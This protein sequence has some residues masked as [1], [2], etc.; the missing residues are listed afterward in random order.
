[1]I[2]DIKHSDKIKIKNHIIHNDINDLIHNYKLKNKIKNTL[3]HNNSYLE[4]KNSKKNGRR[5]RKNKK[6]II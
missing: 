4:K 6:F 5:N 2:D 3:I 1:M